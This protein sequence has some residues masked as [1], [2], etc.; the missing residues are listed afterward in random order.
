VA[1]RD[2]AAVLCSAQVSAADYIVVQPLS[3][4]RRDRHTRRMGFDADQSR[5]ALAAMCSGRSIFC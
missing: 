4:R 1:I 2:N 3:F 5:R